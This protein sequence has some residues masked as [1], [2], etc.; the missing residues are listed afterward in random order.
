LAEALAMPSANA[1]QLAAIISFAF[2]FCRPP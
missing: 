1:A 2:M